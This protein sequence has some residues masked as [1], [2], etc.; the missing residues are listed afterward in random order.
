M[1]RDETL[2]G[3]SLEEFHRDEGP[4]VVFANVVDGANVGVIEGGGSAGF[5]ESVL[6]PG[7]RR[8]PHQAET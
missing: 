6:V 1:A 8:L 7:D 3:R 5:G 2:Q 4:A